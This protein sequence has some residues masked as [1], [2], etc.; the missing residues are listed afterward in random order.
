MLEGQ[1]SEQSSRMSAMENA[2][3]NAGTCMHP[4]P[5]RLSECV[6]A[7]SYPLDA[8]R[9]SPGYPSTLMVL[10]IH[11]PAT[12]VGDMIHQLQ[13]TFNRTRQAVITRELIEIISGAAALD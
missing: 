10:F 12:R 11:S 1:A 4:V 5:S 13:L 6:N 3:S 7:P 8:R 9:F 2:S